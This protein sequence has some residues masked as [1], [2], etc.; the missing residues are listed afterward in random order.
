MLNRMDSLATQSANGTYDND[1]DR[2]NLQKEVKALQS[3]I[4]R[5]RRQL[6]LQRQSPAGRI[7]V[8]HLCDNNIDYKANGIKTSRSPAAS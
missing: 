6:Q 5:N 4:D 7:S 3:E 8:R 2:L 1:V